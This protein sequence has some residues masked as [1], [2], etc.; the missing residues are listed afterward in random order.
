MRPDSARVH[1]FA[2]GKSGLEVTDQGTDTQ[3]KL[4][5]LALMC[6]K[7]IFTTQ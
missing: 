7:P 4:Y 1:L 3:G 6:R 5:K 2:R